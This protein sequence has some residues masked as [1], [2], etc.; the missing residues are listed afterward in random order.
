MEQMLSPVKQHSGWIQIMMDTATTSK[1][2]W[3]T[4]VNLAVVIPFLTDTGAL[5]RMEI[6]ILTLTLVA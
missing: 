3:A 5:I 1:V 6:H 2:T 4:I